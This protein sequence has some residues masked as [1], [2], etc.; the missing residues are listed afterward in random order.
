MRLGNGLCK[1]LLLFLILLDVSVKE[2]IKRSGVDMDFI[3]FFSQSLFW[4]F[5]GRLPQS[6]P[7]IS[8]IALIPSRGSE[9]ATNPYPCDPLY[10]LF[11]I[12]FALVNDA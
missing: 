11:S 9:K 3:S 5:I 6:F 7:F 4:I 1:T 12:T 8:F 10:S 2:L